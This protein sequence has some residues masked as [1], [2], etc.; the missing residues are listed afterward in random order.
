MKLLQIK[1]Y[2]ANVL[3]L[4][5]AVLSGLGLY[6]IFIRPGLLPEDLRYMGTTMGNVDFNLPKLLNWLH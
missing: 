3:A 5:G 1:P 2:S 6:F 4:A